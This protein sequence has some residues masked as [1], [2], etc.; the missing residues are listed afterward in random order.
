[1]PAKNKDKHWTDSS[2]GCLLW[3]FSL[4]FLAI[5]YFSE[6]RLK[7]IAARRFRC[8]T[9]GKTLG[10]DA[11]YRGDEAGKSYSLFWHEEHT[12]WDDPQTRTTYTLTKGFHLRRSHAICCYCGVRYQFRFWANTFVLH[13]LPVL[14]SAPCFVSAE[15]FG[16]RGLT[17]NAEKRYR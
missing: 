6:R 8:L 12:V 3:S 10:K 5:L 2:I 9:S 15:S 1:M 11:L 7:C 4:P 13:G 14:E 17:S 16:I